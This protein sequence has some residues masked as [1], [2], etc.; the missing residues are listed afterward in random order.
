MRILIIT[1]TFLSKI[2]GVTN[3]ICH[4]LDHLALR[5]QLE[6]EFTGTATVFTGYLRGDDLA[7]AYAAADIFVFPAAN[8]TF[9]NVVLEAMASGIPV[10]AP[11]SGGVVDHVEDGVNGILFP[12]EDKAAFKSAVRR[13]VKK[14]VLARE[15]GKQGRKMAEERSWSKVLDKLIA[16][17]AAVINKHQIVARRKPPQ[18]RSLSPSFFEQFFR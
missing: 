4:L 17:Y 8:E 15:M 12:P 18:P 2:D 9:G 11:A 14:P 6:Q 10:I 13:L 16:D 5:P 7:H 3:T 1:E